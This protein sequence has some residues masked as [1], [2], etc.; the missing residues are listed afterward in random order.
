MARNLVARASLVKQFSLR[1]IQGRYRGSFL[2]VFWALVT[3]LLMLGVFTF[4][5]TEIF[6]SVWPGTTGKVDFALYLFAGM[7]AYNLFAEVA[8]GTPRLIVGNPNFVKKVVFPLEV[9]PLAQVGS[10][11][12]HSLMSL[13][14]LIIAKLVFHQ[15][16][17]WTILLLPLVYLPL[18]ALSAAVGWVLASLGVFLRDIGNLVAVVVQL[19]F[20]LS[21][22][23][24]PTSN[25]PEAVRPL[26]WLNPFAT[27]IDALRAV[28]IQGVMPQWGPLLIVTALSLLAAVLGYAWFMKIKRA[29]P[30]V[31]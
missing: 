8:S 5:F 23:T 22:I 25:V 24:Y 26:M 1:E 7:V 16:L 27:I 19:L 21:P 28:V 15:S 14:I 18:L 4:V 6:Q 20:F 2:G 3:P 11:L 17:S 12:I 9:L 10:A 13:T 30:D 31:I 29:F